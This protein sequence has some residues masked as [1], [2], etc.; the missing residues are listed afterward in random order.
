M[1]NLE[2]KSGLQQGYV[3]KLDNWERT[4]GRGVGPDTMPLL[5]GGL[6]VGS[7]TYRAGRKNQKLIWS[8]SKLSNDM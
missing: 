1:S 8:V 3:A 2:L 6:R 4:Y 7:S 5:L